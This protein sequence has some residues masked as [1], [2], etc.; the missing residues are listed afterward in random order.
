M[1]KAFCYEFFVGF[2]CFNYWCNV[3]VVLWV[4]NV[5][6]PGVWEIV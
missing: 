3:V 6:V 5:I 2:W 1:V 4:I